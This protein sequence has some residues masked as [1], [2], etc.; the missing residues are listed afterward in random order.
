MQF[1]V[2]HL[3]VLCLLLYEDLQLVL[4]VEDLQE[5]PLDLLI[6][7]H[8]MG[9]SSVIFVHF[10]GKLMDFPPILTHSILCVS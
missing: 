7:R 9:C 10:F 4:E 5:V 6:L 3:Y 1:L 2:L 8:R